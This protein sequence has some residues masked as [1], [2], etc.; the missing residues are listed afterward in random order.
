MTMRWAVVLGDADRCVIRWFKN[1]VN[2][3]VEVVWSLKLKSGLVAEGTKY[4]RDGDGNVRR[5][6]RSKSWQNTAP[7]LDIDGP[8]SRFSK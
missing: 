8:I 3:D 1:M 7:E 4:I 2:G 5:L 6:L